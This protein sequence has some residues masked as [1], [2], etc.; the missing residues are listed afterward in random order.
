MQFIPLAEEIGLIVPIG[1]WVLKT[2]C[3]QTVA[4]QNQGLHDLTH[5]R[6]SVAAPVFR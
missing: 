3:L 1:K 6:Q 2:A 5:G 4:W